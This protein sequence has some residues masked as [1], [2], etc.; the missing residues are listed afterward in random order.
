MESVVT[1][2]VCMLFHEAVALF[3]MSHLLSLAIFVVVTLSGAATHSNVQMRNQEAQRH[4]I[5]CPG[6]RS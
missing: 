5:A 2:S 6:L 4:C 3:S 1:A